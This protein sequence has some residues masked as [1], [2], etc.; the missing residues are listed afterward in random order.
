MGTIVRGTETARSRFQFREPDARKDRRTEPVAGMRRPV[1]FN[2]PPSYIVPGRAVSW[3]ESGQKRAGYGW[4]PLLSVGVLA[5]SMGVFRKSILASLFWAGSAVFLGILLAI[6]LIGFCL[7]IGWALHFRQNR[8]KK[9]AALS[10]AF[11]LMTCATSGASA[12]YAINMEAG[13]PE[14]EQAIVGGIEKNIVPHAEH[15][16]VKFRDGSDWYFEPKRMISEDET[17][18]LEPCFFVLAIIA[19]EDERFLERFEGPVDFRSLGR[20]LYRKL[21]GRIWGVPNNEGASTIP[22]Q[23]A[24]NLKNDPGSSENRQ[25]TKRTISKKIDEAIIAQRIDQ[26]FTAG[27]Q[28]AL[29]SNICDGNYRGIAEVAYDLFGVKDLRQLDLQQAALLA[30]LPRSPAAYNPRAYPA[31]AKERRD[32]VLTRMNEMKFITDEQF[33]KAR[34]AKIEVKDKGWITEP[35]FLN[36]LNAGELK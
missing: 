10:I 26:E 6:C 16:I 36:A 30:A 2:G 34:Q 17:T 32:Q 31:R 25:L 8:E 21:R 33:G 18:I 22:M 35:S 7:C 28:L 20:V 29:Y 4:L 5:V 23:I 24:K 1:P 27:Q 3:P 15:L 12:R 14:Y 11:F 9:G 19:I 13:K